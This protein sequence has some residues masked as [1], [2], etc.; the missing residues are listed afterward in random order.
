[1]CKKTSHFNFKM[2]NYLQSLCNYEVLQKEYLQLS[3]GPP[4]PQAEGSVR[5][6]HYHRQRAQCGT[7]TSTGRG[8]SEGAPLAQ[9]EGSV[10]GHH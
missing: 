1:M 9:A 5:G 2:L 3:E 10:R 7:T 8:L 6:H 4:L